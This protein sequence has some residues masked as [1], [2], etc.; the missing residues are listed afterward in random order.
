ME[1]RPKKLLEQVQDAIRLKHY[2]Y[3]TEKTYVHWIKRYIFFHN[4]QHPKDMGGKEIEAFLT[5]LAVHQKVAASTQNQAL[6]AI[7][8]LYKE[9][10][11]QNL[12]LKV[13]AVRAKQ[14]RYL[15]T[16]LTK[17]EV[18]AII[19]QLSGVY[20][21][22]IK[23]LYGTGLRLT[24]GL[25]LRVKDVDFAQQQII[26]RD[27]KGM[28]S[29]VTMLP[30][31]IAEE[32]KMHLQGVKLLHQQDLQ[33]GYGSVYLPFALERKYPEA[34]YEWIWQFVFPSGNISQDPRSG[35]VRR[36]YL[37]E[38]GLQKALKK[39]VQDAKINKKVGCHTFRHSFAT[40]LLQNGYDIRTVQELLGHKDVKTTMIYTH[41]LNR[42]GKG[43]RSPLDS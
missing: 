35:E 7:L 6:H 21:L 31:S 28:E 15:P 22:V 43:V 33:K 23:L 17:E 24:E 5:D 26:V 3:Q 32:L 1:Q 40:H 10:L 39:A 42:G 14:T 4:K 18:L 41:V 38:S 19:K 30:A 16:V 37:H 34:K 8:F 29:R 13:D 25:Q 9:V 27:G 36:H 2:S 12:D 11:K 20:Q